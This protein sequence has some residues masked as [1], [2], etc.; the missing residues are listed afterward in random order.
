[1]MLVKMQKKMKEWFKIGEIIII[2]E[3]KNILEYQETINLDT[4][5]IANTSRHIC[6]S[7]YE[8]IYDDCFKAVKL[9]PQN[10]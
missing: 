5:N 9:F 2:E 1:M 8:I 6:I 10:F 4:K 7:I 3:E